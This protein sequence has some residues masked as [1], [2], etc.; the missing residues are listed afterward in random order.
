MSFTILGT[1][2]AG[3]TAARTAPITAASRTLIPISFGASS[4]IPI[5]SNDAGRKH[6][7]T[8]GLP[9]FL[10]PDISSPSPALVKIIISAILRSSADIPNMLSSIRLSTYGPSTIPV[11]SIPSKLGS[12]IFWHIHPI[13]IPIIKINEILSNI[14]FL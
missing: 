4:I 11:I 9:I 1:T 7:S 6:I 8:A 2:T 13:D 3:E 5:I 10:S 12:F 14:F